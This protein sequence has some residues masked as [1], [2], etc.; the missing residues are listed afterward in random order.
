MDFVRDDGFRSTECPFIS[1][2]SSEIN[3]CMSFFSDIVCDGSCMNHHVLVC[4]KSE[5]F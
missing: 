4:T 5:Y 3:R 1:L 2:I